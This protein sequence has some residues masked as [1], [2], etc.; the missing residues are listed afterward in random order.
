[1][2]HA[3]GRKWRIVALFFF[4]SEVLCGRTIALRVCF[5]G[6]LFLELAAI[7]KLSL[8]HIVHRCAGETM[9]PYL[10]G[11]KARAS[12]AGRSARTFIL[13]ALAHF[14]LHPEPSDRHKKSKTSTWVKLTQRRLKCSRDVYVIIKRSLQASF[15]SNANLTNVSAHVPGQLQ[16]TG[17]C[18]P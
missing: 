16:E 12:E 10:N 11:R 8:V 6:C 1:M 14:S 15:H 17:R 5:R 7:S 4:V 18:T 13:I 9:I 3:G 2:Q